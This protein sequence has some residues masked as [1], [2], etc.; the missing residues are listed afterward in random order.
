MS[1]QQCRGFR[2]I[3]C[4]ALVLAAFGPFASRPAAA[5]PA[6]SPDPSEKLLAT[7]HERVL[8][9]IVVRSA[10]GLLDYGLQPSEIELVERGMR[11][12][13][14]KRDAAEALGL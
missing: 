14:L 13:L 1:C 12:V 6:T 11:D 4:A 2:R 8:Y 9:G 7:E 5:E 3:L 10:I